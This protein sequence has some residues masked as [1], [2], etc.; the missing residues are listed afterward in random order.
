MKLKF[1]HNY[2]RK[3][4]YIGVAIIAIGLLALVALVIGAFRA[5]CDVKYDANTDVADIVIHPPG[6]SGEEIIQA[7]GGRSS[8][9]YNGIL[10][11]TLDN[12]VTFRQSG[13]A[14]RVK[15]SIAFAVRDGKP[16][17]YSYDLEITGHAFGEKPFECRSNR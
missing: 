11:K 16:E 6:E 2:P 15:G 12:T 7:D 13:N 5:T 10:Q 1:A 14:Y 4:G 3:F 17:V 9:L 8:G